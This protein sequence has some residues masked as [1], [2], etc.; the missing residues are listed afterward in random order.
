MPLYHYITHG[1]SIS[2]PRSERNRQNPLKT[3]NQN[4]TKTTKKNPNHRTNPPWKTPPPGTLFESL[5]ALLPAEPFPDTS[6]SPELAPACGAPGGA[7]RGHQGRGK[8]GG[9]QVLHVALFPFAPRRSERPSAGSGACQLQSTP[10][11]PASRQRSLSRC[12]EGLRAPMPALLAPSSQ[13]AR[14]HFKARAESRGSRCGPRPA[15]TG[16]ANASQ[17]WGLCWPTFCSR[18]LSWLLKLRTVISCSGAYAA[19]VAG[20]KATVSSSPQVA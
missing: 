17:A 9:L 11:A 13:L 6:D 18:V 5:I 15:L 19:L 10:S 2:V 20:L 12:Q 1:L 7:E 16:G 4:Q 14:R 3:K 8:E